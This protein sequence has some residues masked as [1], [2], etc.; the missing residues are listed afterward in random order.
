MENINSPKYQ[1]DNDKL[2]YNEPNLFEKNPN[3]E[4]LICLDLLCEPVSINCGH[5]FCKYCL[6]TYLKKNANCP[7]CRKPTTSETKL[8]NKNIILSD[9]AYSKNP[10]LYEKKKQQ[11][12]LLLNEFNKS[13][14]NNVEKSCFL[15]YFKN[16]YLIPNTKF[17]LSTNDL[18]QID[19]LYAAYYNQLPIAII[20][21]DNYHISSL[22]IIDSF[23][24]TNKQKYILKEDN[25]LNCIISIKCINRFKINSKYSEEI[26]IPGKPSRIGIISNNM[27]SQ[28][29]TEVSMCKGIEYNDIIVI[30][31]L[32]NEENYNSN[33][34]KMKEI[35]STKIHKK[36]IIE[37]SNSIVSYFLSIIKNSSI[38]SQIS[39]NNMLN[40]FENYNKLLSKSTEL[41][42]ENDVEF[43]KHFEN[44]CFLLYNVLQI[45]NKDKINAYVSNNICFKVE[46]LFNYFKK[47][48]SDNLLNNPSLSLYIFEKDLY[49]F[50]SKT[51]INK[52]KSNLIFFSFIV[53]CVFIYVIYTRYILY[54]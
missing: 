9:L 2:N 14:T 48:E 13:C 41:L 23:N 54:K 45:N 30:E 38:S 39:I 50:D 52:E 11:Q 19:M 25:Y 21:D 7:M 44:M 46:F 1:K 40:K 35:E 20:P 26:N 36:Q 42:F 49:R 5:S 31:E 16:L 12:L 24:I 28:D 8:L 33:E 34:Y 4:C 10:D 32:L 27:P 51:K 18:S 29:I 53:V 17:K 6:F 15:V 43:L 22:T 3:L 47:L 37:K